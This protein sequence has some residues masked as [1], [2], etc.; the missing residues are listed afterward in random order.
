MGIIRDANRIAWE[1]K[2]KAFQKEQKKEQFRQKI[3]SAE[4][5]LC[6][7]SGTILALTPI[8]VT[9]TRSVTRLV[10]SV[11]Y[12]IERKEERNRRSYSCYDRSAGHYWELKRK[13]RNSDW[14]IIN[15]RKAK[16]EKLGDILKDMKVL[17]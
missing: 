1:Q 10:N 11:G 7:N 3:A 15:E 13:L 12:R 2:M 14:S 8:A 6:E 17:K 9:V 4:N 5:W 16:G